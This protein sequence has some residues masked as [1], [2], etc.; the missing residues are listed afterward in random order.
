MSLKQIIGADTLLDIQ[1]S[2]L[3]YIETSAAIYEVDG[4][5][6]AS[7]FTSRWC[8]FLNQA[9]KKLC[10][11]VSEAEAMKSGKWICHEDC[12]AISLKSIKDKKPCEMECS[13]GIVIYAAPI[14][15]E[16]IVFGS[17]NAGI[18][19][20]PTDETK[21]R[22]I[23]DKFKVS[24]QELS[25]IAK[26]YMPRPEYVFNAVRNH[27]LTA[28]RTFVS[29]FLRRQAEE[30]LIEYKEHLEVLVQE[31]TAKL[32]TEVEER[33]KIEKELT[34]IFNLSLD[35]ICI[36][37]L[38]YYFKKINPAFEKI[39]GFTKEELLSRPFIEF[40]HPDDRDASIKEMIRLSQGMALTHFAN[41]YLCKDGS[42]KYIE[43]AASPISD[44]GITYAIGRD[45]TKH[46]ELEAQNK[47]ILR[48]SID[49]FIV[50]DPKGRLLD[51]ND[52]FCKMTG[53]SREEALKMSVSDIDA[54]ES[55]EEAKIHIQRIIDTGGDRFE[56]KQRTKDG[57]IIDVEVS[58]NYIKDKEI[59]FS[60]MRDIT[61]RK[62]IERE[63][64]E[65]NYNLQKRVAEEVQKNR[66]KDQLM[67]EQSRHIAI[68]ELLVNIAHQWRQPLCAIG[69]IIQDLKD[70]YN[71]KELDDKYLE[72]SIDTT[73]KELDYLSK[74][75]DDFKN[76]YGRDGEKA[77]F[78]LSDTVHNT[79]SL[80]M[81]YLK[82]RNISIAYDMD[83]SIMIYG[84][85]RE[86]S[87]VI[88]NLVSNIKDVFENRK[89]DNGLIKIASSI[90]PAS[91][92]VIL[93][94]MD[95][96]GGIPDDIL[97]K[98]FDPYFTTKSKRRGTGLGLYISKVMVEKNM[99]GSI[100]VRNTDDGCEFKIEVQR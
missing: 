42:Y 73:F 22:E 2:Y 9:S 10:G 88:L 23:A 80:M 27:I 17:N 97:G 64:N 55:Q 13:G 72:N 91:G 35:I 31:R 67:Y 59:M 62:T 1:E 43:W 20:P 30:E 60:F 12:W 54:I 29:T 96:G 49:S 71:C 66:L 44:E 86:F 58:V 14:I 25:K 83:D 6:A 90:D 57:R 94:I 87:Q 5:Y 77:Y 63:L 70:A 16:D 69:V 51:V 52:S 89:I 39:L 41:R 40:I 7:L 65:L 50:V 93:T 61:D 3:Q 8:D 98:I 78:N 24:S 68:G 33:T 36:A 21:I 38:S 74:T 37:D 48:T 32:Q 75:L 4:N 99:N 19:N 53:Y 95:N 76:F 79:L 56:T 11:N 18:S 26:E 15:V 45:V 28:S 34:D 82:S 84:H 85:T 47:M 46:R 92:N 100:I 81:G